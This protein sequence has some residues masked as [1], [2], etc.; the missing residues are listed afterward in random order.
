MSRTIDLTGRVYGNLT[1]LK[2]LDK[3]KNKNVVWLCKC[4]C[5]E[6][7]E[8]ATGSL[9]SGNTKSCGCLAKLRLGN[10][11]RTHGMSNTLIYKKW[12]K[13][14]ERCSNS[15][16][17]DY[18]HYGGRGIS[19]CVEWQNGF[20][21]FYNWAIANGHHDNLELD[22]KNNDGNYEPSN[23]RWATR[24]Q[25]MMNTRQNNRITINGEIKTLKEWSLISGL[26]VTT[27]KSR[28]NVGY[29]DGQIISKEKYWRRDKIITVNGVTKKIKD[30]AQVIG[31]SVSQTYKL[32]ES[33][34]IE[35]RIERCV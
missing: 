9:K 28:I 24:S 3:R 21:P 22:R 12:Q 31:L 35:Q 23:C 6:Y 1:V 17:K 29:K 4:I 33:G 32:S 10:K 18:K 26:H 2:A 7:A 15:R 13:M 30:W 8:V 5:G 20:V 16:R 14:R 27:I 19:V 25:Q 11:M 34:Q